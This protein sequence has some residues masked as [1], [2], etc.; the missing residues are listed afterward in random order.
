MK[1]ETIDIE[2]FKKKLL[3][4]QQELLAIDAT[5]NAASQIVVLDQTCVGRLSRMDALQAQ[6]MSVETSKRR[7][8]E[9]QRITA[10]LKRIEKDDY[11]YCQECG[12]QINPQ[13]LL[14]N[15]TATLCIECASASE[16]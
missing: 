1:E 16:A 7:K 5:G 8:L 9:L 12:E 6:A 10:A 11:G 4:H 2:H 15:L 3:H 14:S 13:R